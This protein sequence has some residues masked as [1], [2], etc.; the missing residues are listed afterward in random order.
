MNSNPIAINIFFCRMIKS[1]IKKN[2]VFYPNIQSFNIGNS[3]SSSVIL[4]YSFNLLQIIYCIQTSTSYKSCFMI[5]LISSKLKDFF[6]FIF[7]YFG[8]G[9]KHIF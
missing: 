4:D 8:L 9:V 3:S 2:H 7:F 6:I 5:T 1:S